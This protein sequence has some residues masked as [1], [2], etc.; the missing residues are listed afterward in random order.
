MLLRLLPMFQLCTYNNS[1]KRSSR[2]GYQGVVNKVSAFYTKFLAQQWQTIF[3]VFNHCLTTRTSVHDQ[4]KINILQLFH[5]VVNRINVDYATLLGWDFMNCVSQKKDVI[6]Y[7]HFTKLIIVVLMKKFPFIPLR[8]EEDYHSI[9]DDIQLEIHVT[10]DYKEYETMF[11]NVVVPM[12]QPLLV[13]STQGTHRSTPGAHRTP[14]LT[15]GEKDEESYAAKFVASMLHDDVDD[16]RDRIEPESHKEHPKFFDD[17]DD[18]D[19]EKKED[20]KEEKKDDEIGQ[21]VFQAEAPDLISK[22]FDTHAPMIIK[23]LLKQYVQH[24]VIQVHLTIATSS[25]DLPQQLYSKMKRSLQDQ[26][27]DPALWEKSIIEL[28][29]MNRQHGRIILEFVENGPLIWPTIKENG[30]TRPRKYTELTHADAIQADCD[31]KATNIILQGIPNE[32]YALVSH[33]KVANNLWERIQLLMQGTSLTKQ[34]R[35]CK[36]YDEFDKFAYKKGETL[37]NTK[38]LNSLP[39]EWSKFVTDVKLV[40]DLH[41][42]NID[43]LHAYLE[44]HEFHVNEVHLMHKH[45]SDLLA[46]IATHQMTHTNNQLKNSSNPRQQ[47]AIN[48]RIVTLQ[49][50]QGRQ[51]TFAVG[52]T[53]T[54]TPKKSGSNFEKQRTVICYNCKREGYMSKLYT[55]PKR[56][57]EGHATQTVI[58]HNVSYQ[59]DDLDAYNS[60]CDE[61]NIAK[62]ALMENLSQYG[63]DVLAEVHTLDSTDNSMINQGVQVT[64]SLEQSSVVNHSATK[65]TSGSNIIPYSQYVK[66][67]QQAAVQ[68]S[69]SSE[70][71]DALIL[72][73]IEQL[74]TQ[75]INCTKINIDNKSVNDTLTV[76]LKRYKEQVKVLKEGKNVE[77]KGQDNFSKSHEQNAEIDHLKQTLTEQLCENESLIKTV[78]LEPKLYDDNVI[79]NTYTIEIPDSKKTL[80]LAGESRSKMLLKQQDPMVL[81]K[82]FNTKPVDYAVLNQVSQDFKKQFVPQTELSAKQ[83]FWSQNSMNSLYQSPSC[84]PTKVEVP[85]ELPKVSIAVEQYHLESKTFKFKMNQ[86]LNE[87]ERLLEQNINKDIVNIVV[88]SSVNIASVNLHECKKCLKL[89]A[90]LLNKKDFIVKETYDKLF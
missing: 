42:T 22:E 68:N 90:E 87:N 52:T 3:K 51:T 59:A 64:M 75:V 14:T 89:E 47:A 9:K 17:D 4:I 13:V 62:V 74:K 16:F 12:N 38:F 19:E 28:Y 63:L 85:K 1:R 55:K 35:E 70:Q 49:P 37:L 67:T 21:I 30:V 44:Q 77:I 84:R 25:A 20:K 72:Y 11:I 5:V 78:T 31:V 88:N 26:A 8:H 79:Q 48:D 66:E 34:E 53:R 27:N 65:I 6:Q 56:K 83:A 57:R 23:E 24:N 73:V 7:P 29:M 40:Q 80:M 32:I 15:T 46:L 58:T 43:Q 76:E 86:V 2:V 54:Y 18:S 36:L 61:L 10:H 71:Q 60:D 33:H 39:P 45:N 69:S 41:T 50:V 82:T 81:E